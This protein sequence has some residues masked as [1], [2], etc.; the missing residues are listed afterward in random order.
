MQR[1]LIR[2]AG[3]SF[4][5]ILALFV[6]SGI[7]FQLT[8]P[9]S[10]QVPDAAHRLRWPTIMYLG[11]MDRVRLKVYGEPEIAGE[12]EIDSTGQVSIP[13]AGHIKPPA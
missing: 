3:L 8:V 13:L 1:R 9:A 6:R 2:I 10:A 11:P 7:G 4:L 5:F 12:Y